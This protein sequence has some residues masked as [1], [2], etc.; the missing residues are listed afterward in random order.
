[1]IVQIRAGG[2]A[3]ERGGGGSRVTYP[4]PQGIMPSGPKL[5]CLMAKH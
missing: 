2:R 1:M 3:G 4:G 5:Y